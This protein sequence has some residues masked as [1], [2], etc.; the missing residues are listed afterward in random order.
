MWDF[1]RFPSAERSRVACQQTLQE[2][3][4]VL[5]GLHV[6]LGRP[7]ATIKHGVTRFRITLVCH[8]ARHIAGRLRGQHFRWV[9]PGELEDYP[10]S[11][12]GR[13]ISRLIQ[14][15]KSRKIEKMTSKVI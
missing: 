5:T 13:K 8:E 2:Q 1:P 9:R 12:T 11:V 4:R 10:L 6:E 14:P 15:K 7:L 3:V